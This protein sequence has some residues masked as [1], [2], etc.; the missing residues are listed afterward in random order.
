[1]EE[2][3]NY[4]NEIDYSTPSHRFFHMNH[5]EKS[6]VHNH[7]LTMERGQ[8]WTMRKMQLAWLS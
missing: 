4:L 1:M 3:A 2:Q 7:Q 6:A 5:M 8:V